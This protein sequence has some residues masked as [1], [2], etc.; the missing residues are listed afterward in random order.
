VCVCACVCVFVW[1]REDMSTL[2]KLSTLD[3][4]A[5]MRACAN[6]HMLD[7]I[8][9]NKMR[10]AHSYAHT[11][12]ER[13]RERHYL[14]SVGWLRVSPT[15]IYIYTHTHYMYMRIYVHIYTHTHTTGSVFVGYLFSLCVNIYIYIY[16]Y[17]YKYIYIYIY[18]HTLQDQC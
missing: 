10:I 11:R 2:E 16:M 3:I 4:N 7:G 6:A 12:M 18:T 1:F 14:T 13:Q 5:C 8:Q 15:C 17:I 9:M